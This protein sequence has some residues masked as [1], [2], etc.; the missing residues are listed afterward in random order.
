MG[1]VVDPCNRFVY[2][3][4]HNSNNVSGYTICNA[5]V[6]PNCP[7]PD[8]SLISVGAPASA[9][10]GPTVLAV[11]PLGNFVY[12]VDS[13]QNAI[14]AYK[15]SQVGGAL[16]ALTQPTVAT[17]SNPVSITIRGDDQW[18]FV[19][20]NSSNSLSQYSITPA[21]GALSALP[22]ITTDNLPWGVAVR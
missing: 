20:N 15:I 21:T 11:D 6:L 22:T 17:G 5:T 14:S 13:L 12:V 16:S 10:N 8:G 3:A 9:G 1:V 2:V 19:T 4:N 7:N 18:M